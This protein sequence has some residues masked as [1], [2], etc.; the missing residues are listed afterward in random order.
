MVVRYGEYLLR[1][2]FILA[3]VAA[4]FILA[5]IFCW[6]GGALQAKGAA[7]EKQTSL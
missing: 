4:L 5:A 3:L 2:L 7:K 6:I 1:F